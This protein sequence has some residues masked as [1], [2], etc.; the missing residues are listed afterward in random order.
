LTGFL[1]LRLAEGPRHWFEPAFGIGQE[2]VRLQQKTS[3][4]QH[5]TPNACAP[6]VLVKN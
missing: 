4:T 2:A 6:G 3:N 1:G 5:S